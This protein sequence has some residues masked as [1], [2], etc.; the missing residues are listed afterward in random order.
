MYTITPDELAQ[1]RA[2]QN[3]AASESADTIIDAIAGQVDTLTMAHAN[4]V[5]FGTVCRIAVP[6]IDLLRALC[7]MAP[8][9][10]NT[11]GHQNQ[12]SGGCGCNRTY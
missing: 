9:T 7:A 11:Y 8:N 5:D 3:A 2:E 12:S 10:I 4:G 6:I 1:L